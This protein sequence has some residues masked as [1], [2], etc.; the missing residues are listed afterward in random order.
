VGTYAITPSLSDPGN[1]LGNYSTT[2]TN[3][4]LTVTKKDQ[5]ITFNPPAQKTIGDG[6]F[7]VTATTTSGLAAAFTGNTT[8][9]CTVSADGSSV[10]ITDVGVD[11]AAA[12]SLT[13]SQL[14]DG[15]YNRAPD[16]TKLINIYNKVDAISGSSTNALSWGNNSVKDFTITIL[17]LKAADGSIL[18][19]A[20]RVDPGTVYLMGPH[21]RVNP[22]LNK[23]GTSK[24][25]LMDSNGD[26]LKD[27]ICYF[28]KTDVFQSGDPYQTY[29]L[30][31]D[32]SLKIDLTGANKKL[33][34]R[35]IRGT[36]FVRL[37]P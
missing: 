23:D 6:P 32:G 27:L 36:D 34:G 37:D 10:Q 26:G 1:K 17:T 7:P 28:T 19:D 14:G 33:D 13:A 24:V 35:A 21:G 5:T 30:E 11:A 3:G 8:D 9:R 22:M 15:N 2:K 25:L 4:T 31:L 20:A 29:W 18:F 16:V 12:C